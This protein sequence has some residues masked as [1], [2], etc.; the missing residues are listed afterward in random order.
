MS[1]AMS[2]PQSYLAILVPSEVG[3]V[4]ALTPER[5]ARIELALSIAFVAVVFISWVLRPEMPPERRP[6]NENRDR[7]RSRRVTRR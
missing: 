1:E 2:R 7:F 6:T 4:S 3:A 5:E